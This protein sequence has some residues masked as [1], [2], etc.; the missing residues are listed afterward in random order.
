MMTIIRM[1]SFVS[2]GRVKEITKVL[3]DTA[4]APGRSPEN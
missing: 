3:S 2:P 1:V 4:V